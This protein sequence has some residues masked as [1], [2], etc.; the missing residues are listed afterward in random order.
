MEELKE[1][2]FTKNVENGPQSW[3]SN[4]DDNYNPLKDHDY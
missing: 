2:T 4:Q 1:K 3:E